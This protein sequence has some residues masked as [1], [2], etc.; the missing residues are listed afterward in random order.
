MD[1]GEQ[2]GQHF[3]VVNCENKEPF[4]YLIPHTI[5]EYLRQGQ[6]RPVPRIERLNNILLLLEKN[7][8]AEKFMNCVETVEKPKKNNF[9]FCK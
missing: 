3:S 8:N 4:A 9:V 5:I 6:K 2:M 7:W 1:E